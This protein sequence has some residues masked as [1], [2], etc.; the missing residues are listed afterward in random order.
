[1][2]V[3]Y[4]QVDNARTGLEVA[5]VA[6]DY[7]ASWGPQEISLLPEAIRPGRIRDEQDVELLHEN[8]IEEYR[9]TKATGEALD[10]L[11]RITSF[12]VRAVIRIV[13]LREAKLTGA[14]APAARKQSLAPRG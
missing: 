2:L 3:W 12:L 10:A 8:V 6:R 14:D 4:Q 1:M 13:E 7:L 9:A 11:Q 5:A